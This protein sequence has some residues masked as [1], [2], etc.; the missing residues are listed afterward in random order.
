MLSRKRRLL[1]ELNTKSI[2]KNEA[3]KIKGQMFIKYND[4]SKENK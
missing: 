2:A 3:R 1:N 4:K